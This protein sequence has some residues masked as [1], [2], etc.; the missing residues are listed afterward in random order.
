MT[1]LDSFLLFLGDMFG[2]RHRRQVIVIDRLPANFL[3]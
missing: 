1:I 2:F 3:R